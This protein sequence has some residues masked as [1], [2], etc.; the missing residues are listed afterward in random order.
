LP[1]SSTSRRR[2]RRPRAALNGRAGL[3]SLAYAIVAAQAFPTLKY[4]LGH[5]HACVRVKIAG[6]QLELSERP[7]ATAT[8]R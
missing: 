7:A 5:G 8:A 2:C 4:A 3:A 6:G 1:G